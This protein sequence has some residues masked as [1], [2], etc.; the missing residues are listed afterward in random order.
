[1]DS[2]FFKLKIRR[3]L[4]LKLNYEEHYFKKLLNLLEFNLQT[5]FLDNDV[6]STCSCT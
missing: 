2:D 5:Q 1:M 3:R 4:D 6:N